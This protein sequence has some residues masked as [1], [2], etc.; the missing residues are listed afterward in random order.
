MGKPA[1]DRRT[2]VPVFPPI[3]RSTPEATDPRAGK[4][5]EVDETALGNSADAAARLT[6]AS[7]GID[8]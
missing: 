7:R 5:F 4:S 6:R 8:D 1:G 2:C 3:W